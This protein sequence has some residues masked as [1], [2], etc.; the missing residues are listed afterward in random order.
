MLEKFPSTG[1]LSWPLNRPFIVHRLDKDTSGVLLIAK[2]PEMQYYLSKQFQE[3]KI[4]KTYRA[5]VKGK[6]LSKHGEIIA[7]LKRLINKTKVDNLGKPAE[8]KYKVLSS[9]EQVS[10]LEIYPITGRTHQIRAHLSYIGHPILGDTEYGDI[11]EFGELNITRVML[12]AYKI[13][14]LYHK[15]RSEQW[16]SFTAKLPQDFC[17]VLSWFGL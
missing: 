7:P 10:Y 2:K 16:I 11:K 3:H 14:F 12:H 5:I 17:Q 8:T 1:K 15:N 9:N 6:V 13:S 4:K